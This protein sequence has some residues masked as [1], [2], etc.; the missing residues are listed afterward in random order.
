MCRS[1]GPRT[2]ISNAPSLLSTHARI[3]KKGQEVD[4]EKRDKKDKEVLIKKKDKE[5]TKAACERAR[6][7]SE[8][9]RAVVK[10]VY[11]S[12]PQFFK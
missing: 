6:E 7:A 2:P 9:D 8:R 1:G 10:V 5:E 11:I 4:E 3:R 12:D